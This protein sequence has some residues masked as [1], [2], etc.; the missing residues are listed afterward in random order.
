ML[1]DRI[2]AIFGEN[3][4]ELAVGYDTNRYTTSQVEVEQVFA[5]LLVVV[6]VL[7]IASRACVVLN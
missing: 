1:K 4:D 5:A 7:G 2:C 3:P 6:A